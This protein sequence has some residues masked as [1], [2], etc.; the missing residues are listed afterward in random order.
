VL[1]K[2]GGVWFANKLDPNLRAV[3]SPI[4]GGSGDIAI[5]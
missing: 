4:V 3:E 1:N 5:H 2:N